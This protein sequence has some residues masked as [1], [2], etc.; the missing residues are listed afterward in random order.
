MNFYYFRNMKI[1]KILNNKK[2]IF[3]YKIIIQMIRI[4]KF[5]I[6]HFIGIDILIIIQH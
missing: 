3:K 6:L 2:K 4:I 5:Y 1:S